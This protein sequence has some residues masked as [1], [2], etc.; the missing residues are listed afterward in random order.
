MWGEETG[1]GSVSAPIIDNA[2]RNKKLHRREGKKQLLKGGS[3]TAL[4]R[5]GRG[6]G[7]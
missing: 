1:K 7:N 6:G 2:N 3:S 5:K 4:M